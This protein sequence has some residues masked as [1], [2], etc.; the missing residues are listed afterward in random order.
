MNHDHFLQYYDAPYLG[1]TEC[2]NGI[3]LL[4][5]AARTHELFGIH[6]GSTGTQSY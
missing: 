2:P 1:S 5:N 6:R 4:Y 3:K